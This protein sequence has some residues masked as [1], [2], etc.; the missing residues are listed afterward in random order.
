MWQV[1]GKEF[2]ILERPGM[3]KTCAQ[4]AESRCR[5]ASGG[6]GDQCISNRGIEYHRGG[7][8]FI[9][10]HERSGE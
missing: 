3:G 8:A 6:I 9:A 1:S 10:I 4:R 2:V 7:R 5:D